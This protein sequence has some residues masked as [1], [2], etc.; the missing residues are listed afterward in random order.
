M[1]YP[2]SLDLL[3]KQSATLKQTQRMIM[4]PQMQ[5]AIHLLQMPVSELIEVLEEQFQQNPMIEFIEDDKESKSS[6]SLED[7][8]DKDQL[9]EKELSFNENDFEILKKLDDEFRDHFSES[10]NYPSLQSANAEKF[11]TYQESL[12]QA[13]TS[14]FEH[15]MIQAREI[16][17]NPDELQMAEAIIGNFDENG[18]LT[19]S[20]QEI[21]LLNQFSLKTLEKIL[22]QIQTFEPYGIGAT[23]LQESLLIQLS[24]HNKQNTLAFKIIENHYQDLIHNRIPIITKSLQVS[25]EDISLAL[26]KDIARLDLH[27]GLGHF[28]HFIQYITPD[29]TVIDEYGILRITINDDFLPAIRI[30]KHYLRMLKDENLSSETKTFIQEKLLAARWLLHN[31]HQRND[32]LHKILEIL[33]NIDK[34]FFLDTSGKLSPITMKTVSQ[35]L[36]LHESTIARAV[37]NKYIDTPRGILPLRSFF[38]SSLSTHQGEEIS[39]NA[40]KNTLKELIKNEDKQRPFSDDALAKLLG[41]KGINCARR[42]VAKYRL[43]LKLGNAHQRKIFT[44]KK[45]AKKIQR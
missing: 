20:L 1:P 42:T 22:K 37:A 7:Q 12:V 45:T 2:I 44:T 6:L 28:K 43:E 9:P 36:N 4:A 25:A 24:C 30:P 11:K 39:S 17:M 29:A 40:V 3:A 23:S 19:T 16:F 18:F 35:K 10:S 41:K 34:D 31:V 21:A 8:E 14:L 5:Q 13:E 26:K 27:P 33:I 32:T 15:L 38:T